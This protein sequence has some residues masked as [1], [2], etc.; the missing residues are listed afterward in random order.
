[1][2]D[3]KSLD[4]ALAVF[5]ADMPV[6][7]KDKKGQVGNQKTKYADLVQVNAVV[8]AKLNRLGVIYTCAPHMLDDGKFVLRYQL[9]HVPS[10]EHRDGQYPL[11]LS[12]NPQQMGSAI[13]YARR[14]VLLALTGVAADDEDDD[15]NA[16]A[17]RRYAQRA[18]PQR[19]ES[20]AEQERPQAQRARSGGHGNQPP[21]PGEQTANPNMRTA[22][23]MGMI[24]GLFGKV[25]ISDR[26]IR[27]AVSSTVAERTL[28][29]GNDMT[30]KEASGLIDLLMRVV[31]EPEPRRA[32]ADELGLSVAD[33]MPDGGAEA[34][35][36]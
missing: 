3:P 10:G 15:G 7:T 14:Y 31:D 13:T 11:K 33:L 19:D 24:L 28:A 36:E 1:M 17:G 27:L 2:T 21:L 4:E 12:E 5:Q 23:Q 16:A 25:G 20:A 26:T 32:L 6:L 18:A 35:D 29:S 30:K 8:L 9:L 34:G 22:A